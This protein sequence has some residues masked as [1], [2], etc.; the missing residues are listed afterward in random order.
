MPYRTGL[1]LGILGA[2]T[3]AALL[4]VGANVGRQTRTGPRWKRRLIAAGVLLLGAFGVGPA[5]T[6]APIQ[7]GSTKAASGPA[8]VMTPVSTQPAGS[9]P[10]TP[11]GYAGTPEWRQITQTTQEAE[12]IAAGKRGSHPFDSAGRTR[13]LTALTTAG[14]NAD[15]LLRRGHLAAAEVGLLKQELTRLGVEVR[16]YR[17]TEMRMATC[18]EAVSIPVPAAS[19]MSRLQARLPLL[20]KLAATGRLHPKV[21]QKVLAKILADLAILDSPAELAR[22]SKPQLR[23]AKQLATQV[24][25]ALNTLKP[26]LKPQRTPQRKP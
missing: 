26:K 5:C 17:P 20:Q 2:V 25:A 14:T 13:L 7:T 15:A 6:R 23:L 11:E 12:A 18:Y 21:V 22:L 9:P 4:L 3:V 19:S 16:K 8:P 1:I 24:R 10:A